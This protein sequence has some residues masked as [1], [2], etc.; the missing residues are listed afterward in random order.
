MLLQ[1]SFKLD[2]E[3]FSPL[4]PRWHHTKVL[5]EA[6]YL[7]PYSISSANG[8]CLTK[9]YCNLTNNSLLVISTFLHL[10]NTELGVKNVTFNHTKY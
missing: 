5:K 7:H 10:E 3:R 1:Y 9:L 2:G 6:K 4:E 8:W